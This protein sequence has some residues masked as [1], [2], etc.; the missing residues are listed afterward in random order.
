MTALFVFFFLTIVTQK[1]MHWI[2]RKPNKVKFKLQSQTE[3]IVREV[4][5]KIF[6]PINR[7]YIVNYDEM[8]LEVSASEKCAAT[9]VTIEQF[10]WKMLISC[11]NIHPLSFV[12]HRQ[13]EE[14]VWKQGFP[15]F[16]P[17]FQNKVSKTYFT[18]SIISQI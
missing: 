4:Q 9:R 17:R 1:N 2:T 3:L 11:C 16:L 14:L 8:V 7:F 5:S 13:I 6:Y 15:G 12:I 18:Y 10:L